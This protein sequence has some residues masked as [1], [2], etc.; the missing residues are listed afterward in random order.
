M[1]RKTKDEFPEDVAERIAKFGKEYSFDEPVEEVLIGRGVEDNGQDLIASIYAAAALVE[2]GVKPKYDICIGL[3]CDEE[4]G[5][6]WGIKH[7]YEQRRELF[8]NDDMFIVPDAASRPDGG[9]VEMAE[10]NVLWLKAIS[11]GEQTHAAY[12]DNGVNAFEMGID[13][14]RILTRFLRGKYDGKDELFDVPL[15]T[16]NPTKKEA[17]VPNVNTIPG[18]DVFY[19]DC[20]TLPQYSPDEVINDAARI[21]GIVGEMYGGKIR[22]EIAERMDAAP[23]TPEDAPII[24]RVS[25]AVRDVLGINAEIGGI[26]GQTYANPLRELGYDTAV[27]GIGY[28]MAHGPNEFINPANMIKSA[29]VL[30]AAVI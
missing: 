22:L 4:T 17:N 12:P 15:S 5:S 29:K 14:V 25:R 23:P 16:F 6:E 13:Y 26:S 30:V 7:V 27:W 28:E 20:R 11:T 8:G 1:V 10:K 18:D 21:A 3:F 19:M 2:C 24:K 9:L